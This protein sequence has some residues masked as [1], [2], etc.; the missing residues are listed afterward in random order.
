MTQPGIPEQEPGAPYP[1]P[2]V[3]T[4]APEVMQLR[5][6]FDGEDYLAEA[7]DRMMQENPQLPHIVGQYMTLM[8]IEKGSPEAE[9]ASLLLLFTHELLVTAAH[10]DE[11]AQ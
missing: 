11:Q 2:V 10:I 4:A 6:F 3:T 9:R 8:G 7:H 1:L 5:G